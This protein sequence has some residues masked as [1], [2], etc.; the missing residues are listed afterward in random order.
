MSRARGLALG[1]GAPGLG[2]GTGGDALTFLR[3]AVGA[4]GT[5][6]I[7]RSFSRSV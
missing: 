6:L 7:L 5:N 1:L 4:H 2:G 3:S